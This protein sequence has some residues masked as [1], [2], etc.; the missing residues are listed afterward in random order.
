MVAYPSTGRLMRAS[1]FALVGLAGACQPA[2]HF[3]VV[4]MPNLAHPVLCI[5]DSPDCRGHATT[6]DLEIL[7]VDEKGSTYAEYGKEY[8]NVIWYVSTNHQPDLKIFVYGIVPDGWKEESKAKKLQVGK[9]YA[10]NGVDYFQI[11]EKAGSYEMRAY[12]DFEDIHGGCPP[13][14]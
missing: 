7:E 11:V 5:S 2:H 9:C 4:G 13:P 3:S 1:A 8:R 6:A 10:V 12:E 14:D